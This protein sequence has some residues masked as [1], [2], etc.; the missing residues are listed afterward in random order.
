MFALEL[1]FLF[2]ESSGNC[3]ARID[4]TYSSYVRNVQRKY[5]YKALDIDR[6]R[7]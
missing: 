5:K 2:D 7:D 4:L 6:N 1:S 3:Q